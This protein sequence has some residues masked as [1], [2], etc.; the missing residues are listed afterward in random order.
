MF[1][2]LLRIGAT[3]AFCA[4]IVTCDSLP[5]WALLVIAATCAVALIL[6]LVAVEEYLADDDP[7][8]LDNPIADQVAYEQK[9]DL[10]KLDLMDRNEQFRRDYDKEL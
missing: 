4:F 1:D 6:E 2:H 8:D 3:L 10:S 7:T 9:F 5:T